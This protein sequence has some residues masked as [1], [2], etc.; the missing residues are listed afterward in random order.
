MTT[1][2][3]GIVFIV[4]IS[5]YSKFINQIDA[6]NGIR[7]ISRLFHSIIDQNQLEF[8]I[9]EIEGDAILF[10]RFGAPVS[11]EEILD[12]FKTMLSSFQQQIKDLQKYFPIVADMGLKAIVHYGKMSEY[13]IQNFYKLF[14][15]ILVD[16]HRLLKNNI[17]ENTY[18]LITKEY[19]DA[20]KKNGIE[21]TISCGYQQCELYD[22]GNLCYTYFPFKTQKNLSKNLKIA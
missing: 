21:S 22:I 1:N 13:A 19:I 16:A 4:D 7:I 12:Q 3:K 11:S 18:V 8:K 10:Y 15:R 14:G 17:P 6:S 20:L 9:S 2:A 5:G